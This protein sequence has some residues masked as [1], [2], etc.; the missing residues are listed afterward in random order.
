[1]ARLHDRMPV[2]LDDEAVDL[3]LDATLDNPADLLGLLL[4]CPDDILTSYA[5]SPLVNNVRNDGPALIEPAALVA[6]P[7]ERSVEGQLTFGL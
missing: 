7:E 1:M 6:G 2:L 3:W 5:V 4:P